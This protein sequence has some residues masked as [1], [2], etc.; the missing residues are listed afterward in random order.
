MKKEKEKQL[1]SFL[2]LHKENNKL[3]EENRFL[4]KAIREVS[5]N[6]EK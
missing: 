2:R 1:K 5:N 4:M 6:A 3:R